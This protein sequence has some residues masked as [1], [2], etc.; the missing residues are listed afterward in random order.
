MADDPQTVRCAIYTRVSTPEQAEGDFSSLDNQREMSE[1]YIKSQASQG[2][3]ALDTRY[4]DAGFTGSTME[5]P[6]LDQ[7]LGDI[8]AGTVDFILV[9]KIEPHSRS[10]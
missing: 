8:T 4:D 7:L 1:A 10:R 9:P 2:W 3:I 5:R 6:A